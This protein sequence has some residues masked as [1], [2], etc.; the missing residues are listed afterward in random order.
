MLDRPWPPPSYRTTFDPSAER[1]ERQERM[2]PIDGS[3]VF[4]TD[5]RRTLRY[6][7]PATPVKPGTVSI[8][9]DLSDRDGDLLTFPPNPQ[10]AGS[11]DYTTGIVVIDL[12]V[13][14]GTASRR[15]MFEIATA[16]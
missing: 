10:V 13:S 6:Q 4:T 5:G 9:G 3:V 1:A 15:V 11:V 16:S 7:L 12:D 14:P 2:T 8:D